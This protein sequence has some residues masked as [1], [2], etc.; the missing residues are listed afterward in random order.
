MEKEVTVLGIGNI[1]LQDEGFG[2]AVIEAL[3]K[4][5]DFP[6]NVQVIDGGTLGTELTYF[7]E[8]TKKL[9]IVDAIDGNFAPGT[10]CHF[11]GEKVEAYFQ[12]KMSM[13]E[14]GIQDVLAALKVS[15]KEVEEVVVMGYQ[16]YSLEIG[17]GLT[18]DMQVFVEPVKELV[19]KQLEKWQMEPV[20]R[21][22]V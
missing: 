4:E 12:D 2:V 3:Q 21:E 17:V 13:H 14:I 9:L 7:I 11:A 6:E 20:R 8:G 16:P 15:D 19:L 18:G 5:Y 10:F 22:A 1:L